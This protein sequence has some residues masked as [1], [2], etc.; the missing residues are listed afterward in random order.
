M[1]RSLVIALLVG[2]CSFGVATG[3]AA[4]QDTSPR[5]TSERS[6]PI[7]R[8]EDERVKLAR[9]LIRIKEYSNATSLLEAVYEENPADPVVQNLLKSCYDILGQHAKAELLIKKIVEREPDVLSHRTYLAELLA[10]MGRTEES[11]EAYDKAIALIEPDNLLNQ[12]LL[13]HSMVSCGQEDLALERIDEARTISNRPT[14]FALERG[15]ILEGKRRYE[16]ATE[17]YLSILDSDTARQIGNAERRLMAMLEFSGSS[18]EVESVLMNLA[19]TTAGERTLNLLADFYIKSGHF[20]KGFNYALLQDSLAG[21]NGQPLLNFIGQCRHRKSWEQVARMADYILQR[22]P[23]EPFVTEVSAQQADALAQLGR[24]DEAIAAYERVFDGADQDR[25]K[26]DALCGIG[27]VYF[28]I[29]H[30]YPTARAYFDSVVNYY[31]R[32]FGYL[33]ARKSIP[34]CYLREGDLARARKGFSQLAETRQLEDIKEEMVYYLALS[35]FFEKKYDSA[36]VGLRRLMVDYPRGF[37]VN[38]ALELVLLIDEAQGDESLLDAFSDAL[39]FRERGR[40]D[41]TRARLEAVASADNPA[42]ADIALYRLA[43]LDLKAEDSTSAL[44][45]IDRLISE[46]PDSYYLPYGMKMK[47]DMLLNGAAESEEARQLYRRLLESYPDYP[48]AS[49]VRDKLRKLETKSP[50]G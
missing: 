23:Q 27:E 49:E 44:S 48:F 16:D 21:F 25:T 43:R 15:M 20:D 14:L 12:S 3:S 30:D 42:L 29:L 4:A 26:G 28:E 19:D 24:S 50:V 13:I 32:G 9:R 41:S 8:P 40:L 5:V 1:F 46:F 38:D 10:K 39:Y 33:H 47:A 34:H 37:Y 22:Y 7:M 17:E 18:K 31:P 36:E 45:T 2:L 11:K 6:V 35:A